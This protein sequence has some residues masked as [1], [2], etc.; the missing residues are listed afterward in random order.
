MEEHHPISEIASNHGN[1]IASLSSDDGRESFPNHFLGMG[2][3]VRNV[4]NLSQASGFSSVSAVS[5]ASKRVK[6]KAVIWTEKYETTAVVM[7]PLTSHESFKALIPLVK[8]KCGDVKS[9]YFRQEQCCG[10]VYFNTEELAIIC[11]QKFDKF[12]HQGEVITA[13][14][15]SHYFSN[16]ED[17]YPDANPSSRFVKISSSLGDSSEPSAT[18][19]IKNLCFGLKQEKLLNFL[20]T[21][22][23]PPQSVSYHYDGSGMFRG[24]AFAKFNSADQ[25]M[26]AH[27]ELDGAEL[28]G[29]KIRVEFKRRNT[30]GAGNTSDLAINSINVR[31]RTD[32]DRS[33]SPVRSFSAENH[34]EPRTPVRNALLTK[35]T[36]VITVTP[37]TP[38]HSMLP[39][40]PIL[41][42]VQPPPRNP[43]VISIFPP[44]DKPTR[45]V[46]LDGLEFEDASQLGR[47]VSPI[48]PPSFPDQL[49]TSAKPLIRVG[50]EF[51]C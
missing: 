24:V 5:S 29:R 22:A 12:E 35:P 28:S 33:L 51:A 41:R 6:K 8:E 17:A 3:S 42:R 31:P 34:D 16:E 26:A 45:V 1:L 19:V 43:N 10:F 37:S 50:L 23:N 9:H 2:L 32:A 39:V 14:S 27:S 15:P 38:T 47:D 40:S 49:A 21:I 13:S 7:G 46:I 44:L 4:S 11:K 48:K 36:D 30:A 18:L 20:S 25:A